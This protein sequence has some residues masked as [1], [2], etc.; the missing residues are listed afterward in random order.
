MAEKCKVCFNINFDYNNKVKIF[1]IVWT[2]GQ[3]LW[4]EFNLD[5]RGDESAGRY[6][7]GI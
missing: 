5:W 4:G 6:E 2:R 7:V 3:L 1:R